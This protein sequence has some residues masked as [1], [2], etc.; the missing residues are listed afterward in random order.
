MYAICTNSALI[1]LVVIVSS[2]CIDMPSAK[3]R[4]LRDKQRYASAKEEICMAHKEY[5]SNNSMKCKEASRTAYANNL[6][7]KKEASK[8]A[9]AINPEKKKEGSKKASKSASKSAYATIDNIRILWIGNAHK[10]FLTI[11]VTVRQFVSVSCSCL[12]QLLFYFL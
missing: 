5:Y 9:Y 4:R 12:L 2:L 3:T 8:E 11:L 7:R 6:E 10:N 1:I